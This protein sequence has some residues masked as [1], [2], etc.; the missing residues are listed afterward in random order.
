MISLILL[1]IFSSSIT[2]DFG[3]SKDGSNWLIINDGVMGGRS[4]GEAYLTNDSILFQ[5]EI[6]FENNGGFASI[7]SYPKRIDL[8]GAEFIE[9][10]YRLTGLNFALM[11]EENRRFWMPYYSYELETT[12]NEWVTIRIPVNRLKETRLGDFTGKTLRDA[13]SKEFFR[14]G[15]IS[16]EKKADSFNLEIDYIAIQ[17]K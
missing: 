1:L 11:L 7:R 12:D 13:R 6:S 2:Y 5:G 16:K 14:L 3:A 9:L 8:S 15:F 4:I 17:P 10:R